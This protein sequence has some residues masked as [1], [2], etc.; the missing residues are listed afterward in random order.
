MSLIGVLSLRLR[1]LTLIDF[2]INLLMPGVS[3]VGV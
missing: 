3:F 2:E 1:I